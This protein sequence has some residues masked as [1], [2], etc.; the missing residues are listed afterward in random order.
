MTTSTFNVGDLLSSLGAHGIEKQ[1][2]HIAGVGRAAVNPVSG[3]TTVVYDSSKISSSAIKAA[4]KECGYHCTGEALPNHLCEDHSAAKKSELENSI[5]GKAKP[6]DAHAGMAM[7]TS[8][9]VKAEHKSHAAGQTDAM[10]QE[11]GH[12]AGHDMDAMVRDMRN[13]FLIA[14]AFSLPIFAFSPMGMDFIKITP[15]FGLRLDLV[16]FVFA[17]LAIYTQSG[18][19]SSR[20]IGRSE[21]V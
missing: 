19:L 18:P 2:K 5:E 16:L 13:R 4:I 11:M 9:D 10:A 15:P 17:S 20:H 14:L 21:A 12:G 7:P 8:S 1:L 3:T 6:A